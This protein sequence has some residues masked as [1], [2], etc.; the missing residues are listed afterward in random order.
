MHPIDLPPTSYVQAEQTAHVP[1]RADK[2]LTDQDDRSKTAASTSPPATYSGRTPQSGGGAVAIALGAGAG[3]AAAKSATFCKV[4]SDAGWSGDTLARDAARLIDNPS[5]R[6]LPDALAKAGINK[7]DLQH[8]TPDAHAAMLENLW[9]GIVGSDESRA[10]VIFMK[11]LARQGKLGP[12]VDELMAKP[13]AFK[14]M[15]QDMDTK[16]YGIA[17]VADLI[18]TCSPPP[19]SLQRAL[20]LIHATPSDVKK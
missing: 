12:A 14:A 2:P 3:A 16:H 17:E 8:L 15:L 18:K 7:D 4:L 19:K 13:E 11:T 9:T 20:Q 6:T 5:S 10:G 1:P